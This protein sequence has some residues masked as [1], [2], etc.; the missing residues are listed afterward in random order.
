M[1]QPDELDRNR[2]RIQIWEDLRPIAVPDSRF[3]LDFS[4]YIPDYP[5]SDGIHPTLQ[6]MPFYAAAGTVFV[7]PD[8]NLWRL[9]QALL[10]EGRSLLMTTYGI[11]R[12][13]L[14][15]PGGSVPVGQE[16]FAASLD[17]AEI[18]ARRITLRQVEDLGPLDFLVTGAS[19]ISR[20]GIRF[21]KGH[22]YFDLE[23]AMLREIGAASVDTPVV[24][25]VHDCQYIEAELS[26]TPTDT[27]VDWVLTPSRTIQVQS[28]HPKP[29]GV[30]WSILDVNLLN[31]VPPL[32][33]LRGRR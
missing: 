27:I 2:I 28:K 32:Q 17:G 25:C 12:G 29:K 5:G 24:G 6:R 21:G 26:A 11:A 19:A 7:T 3:D 18:Y 10:V 23:W 22:G 4:M 13:F 8:N 15:F 16:P 33:E 31:S 20:D 14:W 30:D 1:Q 9:R